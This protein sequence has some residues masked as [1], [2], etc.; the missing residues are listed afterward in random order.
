MPA[1]GGL[2]LQDKVP[3]R[4]AELFPDSWGESAQLE[5]P[6]FYPDQAKGGVANRCSHF[7]DLAIFSLGQFQA[8]PAVG[9][10]FS[11]ADG[12]IPRQRRG[13]GI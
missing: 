7:P 10:G 2:L 1:D 3:L 5:A 6:D 12:R 11:I 9:H 13:L 4:G 8:D